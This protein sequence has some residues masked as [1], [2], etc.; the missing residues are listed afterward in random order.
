MIQIWQPEF[1]GLTT[2]NAIGNTF[3]ARAQPKLLLKSTS[4]SKLA[5][6]ASLGCSLRASS[7][8]DNAWWRCVKSGQRNPPVSVCVYRGKVQTNA[9]RRVSME[10]TNL[11]VGDLER[12]GR[13]LTEQ[14]LGFGFNEACWS[15]P[16]QVT[17]TR[18]PQM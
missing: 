18:R 6:P 16:A 10:G 8:P 12:L 1:R 9:V 17:R 7:L 11:G 13:I 15:L 3:K 5:W 4:A 14:I 2:K